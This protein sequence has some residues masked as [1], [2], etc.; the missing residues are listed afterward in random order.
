MRDTLPTM[1]RS[2]MTSP[3]TRTCSP[4]QAR[5]QSRGRGAESSGGSV[6]RSVVGGRARRRERQR[7][8][9]QQQHQELGV[10]EV[11]LEHAGGEHRG[12]RRQR[13]GGQRPGARPR[14]EQRARS[15]ERDS[16]RTQSQTA[17][18]GRPRSAAIWTG[19]L[20]RC[21]LIVSTAS[22]IAV[23]ARTAPRPCSVRRRPADGR[24]SCAR[25]R[26]ASPGD[27]GWSDRSGRRS[28]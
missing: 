10:A 22:R 17:S 16:R 28:T 7:H 21:G 1:N 20:C 11:V 25:L 26:A 14:S 27:R 9:Q 13:G 6:M 18:A 2:S 15:I 5:D 23:L 8:E 19:T 12:H 24:G 3:T 4:R